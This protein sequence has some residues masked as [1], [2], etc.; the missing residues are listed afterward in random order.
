MSPSSLPRKP[1]ALNKGP[2]MFRKVLSSPPESPKKPL[3][4]FF[5]VFR[6]RGLLC[7]IALRKVGQHQPIASNSALAGVL[8]SSSSSTKPPQS[9]AQAAAARMMTNLGYVSR[10]LEAAGRMKSRFVLRPPPEQRALRAFCPNLGAR[11]CSR[12]NV[13]GCRGSE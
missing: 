13:E 11:T 12:L 7:L 4:P 3:A 5:N 2:R 9:T 6:A 8:E 1:F 10:F